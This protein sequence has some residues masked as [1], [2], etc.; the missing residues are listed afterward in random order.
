MES[1]TAES[2]EV[3]I[4][5]RPMNVSA[6][7]H[8]CHKYRNSIHIPNS[9]FCSDHTMCTPVD[10]CSVTSQSLVGLVGVIVAVACSWS[11][12]PLDANLKTTDKLCEALNRFKY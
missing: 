8:G 12:S 2:S 7:G 10:I 3:V 11:L 6:G 5:K 9:E 1:Q 4:Q